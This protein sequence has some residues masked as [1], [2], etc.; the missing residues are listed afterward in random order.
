VHAR[1][2]TVLMRLAF[3]REAEPFKDPEPGLY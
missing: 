1:I 2:S 3:R